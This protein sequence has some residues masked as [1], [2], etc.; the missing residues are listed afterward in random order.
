MIQVTGKAWCGVILIAAILAWLA[1]A[2]ADDKSLLDAL[3]QK[4]VLTQ[5]E[6]E[7]LKGAEL[8]P[9]QRAGLID[10]LRNKGLLTKDEAAKLESGAPAAPT[11][12]RSR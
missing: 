11:P 2:R 3:R 12:Q 7:R 6:Y 8:T 9:A 10:V 1:P 4:G 5:Q